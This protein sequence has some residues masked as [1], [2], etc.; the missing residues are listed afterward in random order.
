VERLKESLEFLWVQFGVLGVLGVW[1]WWRIR[2]VRWRIFFLG[3]V[4]FDLFYTVF[5]NTISLDITPFNLSVCVGLAVGVGI[6]I[7]QLLEEV[8]RYDKIGVTMRK[9]VA[10][11]CC[12]IPIL[13]LLLHFSLCDQSRNYTAYEQGMNILRTPHPGS[14]LFVDADN[15]IFPVAFCRLVERMGE[16]LVLYDRQAVIFKMPS[17]ARKEDASGGPWQQQRNSLEQQVIRNQPEMSVFYAILDPASVPAAREKILV[18]HGILYCFVGRGSQRD[19][20]SASEGLWRYYAQESFDDSFERDYMTRQ[21]CAYFHLQRGS[22]MMGSGKKSLGLNTIQRASRIG[23]DDSG[24]HS[25]AAILL[26][27]HGFLENAREE[28]EKASRDLRRLGVSHN[29]WGLYYYQAGDLTKAIEAFKKAIEYQWDHPLY[30]KNLGLALL[31]SGA[32]EESILSLKNSLRINP[33]QE[34]LI[35]FMK[36]QGLSPRNHDP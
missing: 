8:R 24:V 28:L 32:R 31:K 26:I 16:D 7:S 2:V 36:E 29:N 1:G 35:D 25:M 3:V 23:F 11:A 5:L 20:F 15:Y 18:P 13:S 6:G 34:D 30:H 10:G 12:I 22:Q 21:V 27:K 19:A 9:A 33:N 17:L 4:V 14:V